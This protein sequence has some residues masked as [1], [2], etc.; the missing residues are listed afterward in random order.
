MAPPRIARP[1]RTRSGAGSG[2]PNRLRLRRA[3]YV[4]IPKMVFADECGQVMDHPHWDMVVHDGAGYRTPRRDELI[5]LPEGSDLYLLPGRQPMGR[6]PRTRRIRA[7]GAG[8]GEPVQ[9]MAAFVAPAY[10]RLLHPAYETQKCAPELPLFA[11]TAVGWADERF[12]VAAVRVDPERRQDPPLFD[13]DAIESAVHRELKGHPENR[14][15]RQLERCALEYGCRAAQNF[16]LHRWEAPLPTARTCNAACIGCISEQEDDRCPANH[17]RIAFTPTAEEVAEVAVPHFERVENAVASFG[18]GCEGEPL[19]NGAL[20][21]ESIRLIRSRTKRGTINLNSNASLPKT[22]RRLLDAGLDSL[23]VTIASAY[24]PM[25]E[26][27]HRPR[28][29]ELADVVASMH[30]VKEAGAFLS[31]NLLVFP[32]VT[33]TERELEHLVP[34]LRDPGVDLIQMRN[35]NLDPE[36]YLTKVKE[37]LGEEKSI[38]LGAFMKRLKEA[39]PALKFGY[40]N[41]YVKKENAE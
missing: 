38:G 25:Y 19:V 1:S 22:V 32:G 17:E 34:L 24:E 28:G 16:Y 6:E 31:L 7:F 12:W 41:P 10:L 23:R 11:Y 4:L 2:V 3:G 30:A 20:L 13:L 15:Y 27:Y 29:Y 33:D 35:L 36:M 37:R 21:E 40:F 8:Y 9:A 14:L 26:L 39:Q 18:Q 5:P